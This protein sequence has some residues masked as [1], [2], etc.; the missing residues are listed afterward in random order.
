MSFDQ[1]FTVVVNITIIIIVYRKTIY[2]CTEHIVDLYLN[3]VI[4][5]KKKKKII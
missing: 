4:G 1:F 2:F 3:C 5:I